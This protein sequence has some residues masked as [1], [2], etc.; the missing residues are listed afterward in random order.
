MHRSV[1]SSDSSV[2]RDKCDR[3]CTLWLAAPNGERSGRHYLLLYC[4]MECCTSNN[5]RAIALDHEFRHAG[6]LWL[7]DAFSAIVAATARW[8]QSAFELRTHEPPLKF[9]QL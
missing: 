8:H 6:H 9:Y 7:Q 5:R 3:R 2:L 1:A 4:S